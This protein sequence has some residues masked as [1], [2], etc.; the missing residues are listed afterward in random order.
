M[1]QS[2]S[3][4]TK[5][6]PGRTPKPYQEVVDAVK[7]WRKQTDSDRL[8]PTIAYL[9]DCVGGSTTTISRHRKRLMAEERKPLLEINNP[10]TRS[11]PFPDSFIAAISSAAD[12]LWE[13]LHVALEGEEQRL[14]EEHQKKLEIAEAN[15]EQARAAQSE[16]EAERDSVKVALEQCQ[17]ELGE[18]KAA[19]TES[20]E[21]QRLER[22]T[23]Y[24]AQAEAKRFQHLLAQAERAHKQTE[25]AWQLR[26]DEGRERIDEFKDAM[27]SSKAEHQR[28]LKS[29]TDERDDARRLQTEA[30]ERLLELVHSK[31]TL[32]ARAETL[33]AELETAVEAK[34][35]NDKALDE[36]T[37]IIDDLKRETAMLT[38]HLAEANAKLDA[39]LDRA[40]EI[41]LQ[42]QQNKSEWRARYGELQAAN[43]ALQKAIAQITDNQQPDAN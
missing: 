10:N 9:V 15:I 27:A 7:A 36:R 32:T 1:D 16:A 34:N 19:L 17:R 22:D 11:S 26:I 3:E 21:A 13:E 6:P 28:A 14:E 23:R 29:L 30:K 33:L 4:I 24:E 2:T 18:S 42:H 35:A 20:L 38:A 41:D 37:G 39:Q 25:N 40:H 31:Q 12:T 5:K 43:Q 8:Y